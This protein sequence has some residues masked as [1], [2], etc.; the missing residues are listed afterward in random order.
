LFIADKHNLI[1]LYQS[2]T[3]DS[4]FWILRLAS[5]KDGVRDNGSNFVRVDGAHRLGRNGF[6]ERPNGSIRMK[7][8]VH[9]WGH[10]SKGKEKAAASQEAATFE[11]T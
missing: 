4:A 9:T 10:L 1:A 11:I 8:S 3:A 6:E 2:F 5:I 7:V